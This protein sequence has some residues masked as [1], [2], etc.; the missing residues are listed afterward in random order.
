MAKKSDVGAVKVWKSYV[1]EN[2]RESRDLNVKTVGFCLL[3]TDLNRRLRIVLFGLKS[4]F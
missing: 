1:G 3:K 2:N 4:G